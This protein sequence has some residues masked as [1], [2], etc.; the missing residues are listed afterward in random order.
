M[1]SKEWHDRKWPWFFVLWLKKWP[2]EYELP[3]YISYSATSLLHRKMITLE[4]DC[5]SNRHSIKVV[6]PS[7]AR[8]R[9]SKVWSLLLIILYLRSYVRGRR[10]WMSISQFLMI[11]CL[12][13][14]HNN[15]GLLFH[16]HFGSR[17]HIILEGAGCLALTP[18]SN[19]RSSYL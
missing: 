13:K 18:K 16:V 3:E 19:A 7:V 2:S 8:A 14:D 11:R 15:E 10:Q 1:V 5:T 12:L 9:R 6:P 4:E 17:Y